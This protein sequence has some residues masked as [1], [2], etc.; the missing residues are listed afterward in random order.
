[1]EKVSINKDSNRINYLD[2][3]RGLAIFLVVFGHIYPNDTIRI[4]LYSFHIPLFFIVS[5]CLLNYQNEENKNMKQIFIKK[6]KSLILPYIAFS[7]IRLIIRMILSN[8]SILVIMG[9]LKNS[10]KLIGIGP[11]WFLPALFIAELLFYIIRKT[12]KK[13]YLRI[14]IIV[15]LLCIPL[16]LNKNSNSMLFVLSRSFISLGFIEIGYYTYKFISKIDLPYYLIF[17]LVIATIFLSHYN[18]LVDLYYLQFNV[19]L[20]YIFNAVL[21][22]ITMILILKKCRNIKLLSF[23][24]INSLIIMCTHSDLIAIAKKITGNMLNGYKTGAALI[25]VILILEYFIIKII[26]K[27]MP[28][29]LGKRKKHIKTSNTIKF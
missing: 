21:G 23:W 11:M 14:I 1:M 27:H 3:A 19:F 24:G 10:I 7:I 12:I 9:D 22:S 29:L 28:F 15:I 8:F 4:W 13:E 20:L 16:L 18:G 6:V 2:M 25:L 26:N 17:I 5:G